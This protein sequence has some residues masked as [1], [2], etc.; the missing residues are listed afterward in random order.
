[1]TGKE[2][3]DILKAAV[4][5][6]T[7]RKYANGDISGSWMPL[8]N[9][10]N[11][12]EFLE[13]CE[14]LHKD[15]DDPEFMFQDKEYLPDEYYSESC[16]CPEVFAVIAAIKAMNDKEQEAFG[17]YC[18]KNAAIPEMFDVEEFKLNYKPGCAHPT[19]QSGN[20]NALEELLEI[21]KAHGE[22]CK[23][24]YVGAIKV[25]DGYFVRFK[26]QEL[27]KSFCFGYSDFGQGMTEEEAYE[28]C[29][30]F[31]EKE[32]KDENL[33]RFDRKYEDELEQLGRYE[34]VTLRC[35]ERTDHAYTVCDVQDK[36]TTPDPEHELTLKGEDADKFREEYKNTVA[37]LRAAFEKKI[38]SYL[39]RYGVSKIRKWTYWVDE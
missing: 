38:D 22:D 39:K 10:R 23:G 17:K 8:A 25:K 35:T 3:L 12:K 21:V 30:N 27:E 15:E 5:C 6:G 26:K 28:K 14:K 33:A 36:F 4:Y 11:S 31:G 2:M 34:D 18:D 29:S 20:Q 24:Y 37:S 13:A 16:I 7:Y 19:S 1:M 32:F 9:Y